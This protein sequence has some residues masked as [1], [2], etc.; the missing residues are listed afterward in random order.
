MLFKKHY[1][2]LFCLQKHSCV[3]SLSVAEQEKLLFLISMKD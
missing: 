1:A 3:L 2:T